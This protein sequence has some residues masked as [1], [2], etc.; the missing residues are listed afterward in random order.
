MAADLRRSPYDFT[1]EERNQQIAV[2][3]IYYIANQIEGIGTILENPDMHRLV[4][5][6]GLSTDLRSL[7]SRHRAFEP[8]APGRLCD[9]AGDPTSFAG[10]YTGLY[11]RYLRSGEKEWLSARI[12]LKRNR[13]RIVGRFSFGLGEGVLEGFLMQGRQFVYDWRWGN[14]SGR[15][16]LEASSSGGLTGN[17]GYKEATQGVGTWDL[18]TAGSQ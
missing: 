5:A 10:Q 16:F 4:V 14:A 11:T 7:R 9:R 15:G 12:V 3:R 8:V 18:C 1:A 17:W 13:N 2:K 6:I